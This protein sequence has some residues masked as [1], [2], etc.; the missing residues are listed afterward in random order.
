[1]TSGFPTSNKTYRIVRY[2]ILVPVPEVI[3]YRALMYESIFDACLGFSG[4][5]TQSVTEV[6]EKCSK[7][8][9]SNQRFEIPSVFK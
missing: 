8:M 5:N 1:M 7:K 2:R 9:R 6:E 4:A 3:L